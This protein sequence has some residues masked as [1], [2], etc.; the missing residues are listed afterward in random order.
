ML[1]VA[2]QDVNLTACFWSLLLQ[3][4]EQVHHRA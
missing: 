3:A 2:K 4:H 1:V